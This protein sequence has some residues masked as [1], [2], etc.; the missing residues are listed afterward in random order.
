M[1]YI[2]GKHTILGLQAAALVLLTG[3]QADGADPAPQMAT[4]DMQAYATTYNDAMPSAS[5]RAVVEWTPPTGF[6]KYSGQ[7]AIRVAFMTTTGYAPTDNN[8]NIADGSFSY[9]T[10]ES[11]WYSNFK[12]E[13]LSGPYYLYGY[14]PSVGNL[15]LAPVNSS[16]ANGATMTM[17]GLPTATSSD[18]CVIVGV[19][20]GVKTGERAENGETIDIIGDGGIQMGKFDYTFSSGNNHVFLLCDHIYAAL[21]LMIW[22]D[23]TYSTLRTIKLKKVWMTDCKNGS[24]DIKAKSNISLVLNAN[25]NGTS[26]INESSITYTNDGNSAAMDTLQKAMFV[27]EKK[28]GITLSGDFRNP[29]NIQAGYMVPL[30]SMTD[31]T[32][33]TRYD[34]YDTKGNLIRMDQYAANK[35]N[36]SRL[37][38]TIPSLQ[39]GKRYILK[40]KV[41]PTYL[42]VLSEPDLDNP[43]VE[44]VGSGN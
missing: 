23:E 36:I 8:G 35:I 17:T 21:G 14:M 13:N 9:S 1:K 41:T 42:Y 4:L 15:S 29:T 20:K 39:R 30:T 11:K 32:L 10:G 5:T 2:I 26:P 33:V 25:N 24:T 44:V 28:E 18:V 16:Y 12:V 31:F 7:D 27:S 40:L 37:F 6:D 38:P 34:V 3:C 22:V 19:K 43:T